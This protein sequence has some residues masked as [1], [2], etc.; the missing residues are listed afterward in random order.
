MR[1]KLTPEEKRSNI[2]GIKVKIETRQQLEWIAKR[3][4]TRLSTY[5]D[6]QLKE[7]IVTYFKF[8]HIDWNKLS[9]EEKGITNPESEGE[10]RCCPH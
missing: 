2:I 6:E 5:I 10:K 4:A 8:N 9:D 3:E 1:K 7:H